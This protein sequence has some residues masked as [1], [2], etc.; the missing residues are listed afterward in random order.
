MA[1][2]KFSIIK[3]FKLNIFKKQ[4]ISHQSRLSID[5]FSEIGLT[6][7]KPEKN[8]VSNSETGEI[9]NVN[10]LE[11]II[12][13]IFFS[14]KRQFF[15]ILSLNAPPSRLL[16]PSCDSQKFEKYTTLTTEMTTARK[17]SKNQFLSDAA[18]CR[19]EGRKPGVCPAKIGKWTAYIKAS[20]ICSDD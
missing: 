4:I 15:Y 1:V 14:A 6:C 16:H 5:L 11:K 17:I 13:L 18:G 12:Y 2:F 7:F 8:G 9:K 10:Q 19:A 3:P 20:F